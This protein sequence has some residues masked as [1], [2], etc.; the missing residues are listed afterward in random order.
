MALLLIDIG[1]SAA[2]WVETQAE[3]QLE[4]GAVAEAG[5]LRVQV[6]VHRGRIEG[7]RDRLLVAW[8]ALAVDAAVACSVAA[9]AVVAEIEAAARARKLPV[10]WLQSEPSYR[11]AFTLENAYRDPRQLGA[12]RWHA[13]IGAGA[14][15]GHDTRAPL[16]VVTAGTA[17]TVDCLEAVAG[18]WRFIGG[19]IAPGVRLML[20]SLAQGTADL[21]YALGTATAFPVHTDDAIAS[22]VLDAQAG[23][24][25]RVVQRFAA[26]LDAQPRLLLGGGHAD[27]LAPLLRDAGID[28]TIEDNLVLRGLLARARGS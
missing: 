22:G 3:T 17:T 24:V 28:L 4:S 14:L 19:V 9:P 23:L 20:E 8:Q 18:G 25:Q 5:P 12:D 2:K 13:L 27:T 7:L 6:E 21:P 26:R 10:K 16:V 11:G 1:N 15:Q